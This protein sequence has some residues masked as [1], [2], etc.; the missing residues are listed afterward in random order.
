VAFQA[1]RAEHRP[2]DHHLHDEAP[3]SHPSHPHDLQPAPAARFSGTGSSP[4]WW[5]APQRLAC[6]ALLSVIV[7]LVILWA[8]T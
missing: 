3:A 2:H 6:A 7:W 5:S 1:V 8:V 4:L